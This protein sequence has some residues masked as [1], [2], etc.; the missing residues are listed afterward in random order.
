MC[1]MHEEACFSKKKMFTNGLNM[2]F[3]YKLDLK[4]SLGSRNSL[5]GKEKVV[6]TAVSKEGNTDY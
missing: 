2:G 5:S 4:N 3:H 6:G 1:D